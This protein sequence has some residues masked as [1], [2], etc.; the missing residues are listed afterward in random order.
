MCTK[1]RKFLHRPLSHNEA[2][3]IRQSWEINSV[4]SD[5]GRRYLILS[6]SYFLFHVVNTGNSLFWFMII[7]CWT[8]SSFKMT[9]PGTLVKAP[10]REGFLSGCYSDR[11]L[12]PQTMKS[13]WPQIASPEVDGPGKMAAY[14]G[15]LMLKSPQ[16]RKG[17][18][19][20][21]SSSQDF[22]PSELRHQQVVTHFFP[23]RKLISA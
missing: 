8:Q 5:S 21:F 15:V 13:S 14:S 23:S 4:G 11:C 18:L 19:S 2:V 20:Y 17:H 16:Q 10:L 12:R 6:T 1:W 9:V 7:C 22:A 3:L